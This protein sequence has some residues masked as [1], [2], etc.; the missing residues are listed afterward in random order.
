MSIYLCDEP[1]KYKAKEKIYPLLILKIGEF[2]KMLYMVS[3]N[4]MH[5]KII[6]MDLVLLDNTLNPLPLYSLDSKFEEVKQASSMRYTLKSLIEGNETY[7]YFMKGQEPN[8]IVWKEAC[9]KNKPMIDLAIKYLENGSNNKKDDV[10]LEWEIDVKLRG[11]VV[12][13]EPYTDAFYKVLSNFADTS[14]PKPQSEPSEQKEEPK[15]A[16]PSSLPH[17]LYKVNVT[18]QCFTIDLWPVVSLPYLIEVDPPMLRPSKVPNQKYRSRQRVLVMIDKLSMKY[19]AALF[20]GQ[21]K[22]WGHLED[23]QVAATNCSDLSQMIIIDKDVALNSTFSIVNRIGFCEL[24]TLQD[25]EIKYLSRSDKNVPIRIELNVSDMATKMCY[26]GFITGIRAASS[27][28]GQISELHLSPEEPKKGPQEEVKK[29]EIK[30]PEVKKTEVSTYE[31][32]EE[33]A[34]IRLSKELD[35]NLKEEQFKIVEQDYKSEKK[36]LRNTEK[37]DTEGMK[38]AFAWMDIN[39]DY[40]TKNTA[41]S[42]NIELAKENMII[43][44]TEDVT[45][46]ITKALDIDLNYVVQPKKIVHQYDIEYH[47]LPE[48]YKTP[49]V[50][51]C[52]SVSKIALVLSDG[53]DLK[54][55]PGSD[56]H[57]KKRRA[58]NFVELS[59]HNIGFVY[60]EF[61]E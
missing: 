47:T 30:N 36:T 53:T 51:L 49:K 34:D 33:K 55:S 11:V 10:N 56:K 22:V 60:N 9:F 46:A 31:I 43:K 52:V 25:L 35:K 42:Q 18:L 23:L 57:T 20:I 1:S 14:P 3:Q 21:E 13:P 44:N 41:Q 7:E 54:T 16:P 19:V 58:E 15:P 29:L 48:E 28:L 26:D 24:G 50:K 17:D 40:V 27:I 12:R 61:A 37:I 5:C 39:P 6:I 4:D 32:E 38:Q 8:I 2:K 59:I 45:A